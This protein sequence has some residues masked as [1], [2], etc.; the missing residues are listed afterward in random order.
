MPKGC[1]ISDYSWESLK[2]GSSNV[3]GLL[4]YENNRRVIDHFVNRIMQE[5]PEVIESICL[6]TMLGIGQNLSNQGMVSKKMLDK[7]HSTV[8]ILMREKPWLTQRTE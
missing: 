8:R 1:L 7:L 2:K 5:S 6:A 3:V 4:C